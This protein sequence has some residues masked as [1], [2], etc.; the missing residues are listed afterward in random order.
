MMQ[1]ANGRNVTAENTA[2]RNELS[3]LQDQLAKSSS[4]FEAEQATSKAHCLPGSSAASDTLQTCLVRHSMQ[5]DLE[6]HL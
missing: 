4:Q 2:L 5:C 3:A 6:Q 1:V